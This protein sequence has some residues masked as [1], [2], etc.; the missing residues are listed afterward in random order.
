MSVYIKNISGSSK[1]VRGNVMDNNSYILINE[2]ERIDWGLDDSVFSDI[3]S[4]DLIIAKS[5]DGLNDISNYSEQWDYLKNNLPK[6]ITFSEED[7]T[8]AQKVISVAVKRPEGSSTTLCTHD[9]TNKSTWY[10]GSIEVTGETL[11]ANGLTYSAVND[12]WIDLEHGKVYNEY[13]IENKRAP[14]IYDNAVLITT[15]FTINYEDGEIVFD[16]TP[17]GPITADYWHG[18]D[19]TFTVSPLSG[20]YLIIEHAELNFTKDIEMTTPLNFEI[21]VYNP[22]DLP[23]KVKYQNIKYKNMKD[24]ISAANL[25]QGFIQA[26]GEITKDILIFPFNYATVKPLSSSLGAELRITADDNIELN[27]EWANAA[28]YIL[29]EDE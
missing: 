27:G 11:S 19:S 14:K 29:S 13:A 6:I 12:G 22:A 15:G 20:K 28:F 10:Q 7:K 5:D 17:T 24:I 25:G 16:N 21:W 18:S 26:C 9:F 2:S 4:D 8:P 3:S 23:N 1:T